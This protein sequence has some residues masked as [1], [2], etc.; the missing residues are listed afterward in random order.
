[1]PRKV[2][3]GSQRNKERTKEKLIDAVG[4]ILLRD[5]YK[6]LG[7][8]KVAKEAG[9]DKKLIYRYY[10]DLDGLVNAYCRTRDFWSIFND[11]V[12][13]NIDSVQE[14]GAQN[15]A[16]NLLQDLLSHFEKMKE[17]QK[18]ILW[19][20]SE[21]SNPLKQLSYERE[22]LG[23]EL[24][25]LTDAWFEG[26]KID[27]RACFSIM[28]AGV[29]YLVLHSNAIGGEFCEIDLKKAT[30]KKRVENGIN[31]LLSLCYDFVKNEKNSK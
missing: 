11:V 20:I 17:A 7:I 16:K 19:E 10:D 8:N 13:V 15:L 27:I 18:I 9:V 2:V 4:R 5:G 1:M 25:K 22:T 30:G 12:S 21:K 6:G 31:Q 3:D 24:F 28:L 26:S 29:Y 14:D 23:T